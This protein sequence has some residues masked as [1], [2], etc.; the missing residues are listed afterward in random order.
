MLT[1]AAMRALYAA[2]VLSS[3][4]LLWTA[5]AVARL[6]RRHS[7]ERIRQMEV[8]EDTAAASGHNDKTEKV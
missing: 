7:A 3:A 1:V 8:T 4:V 5:I 6:I 2:F